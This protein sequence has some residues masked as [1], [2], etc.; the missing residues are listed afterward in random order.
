MVTHP[1]LGVGAGMFHNAEELWTAPHNSF[2]Q[3][4]AELGLVG[5][6]IFGFLLYRGVKNC[7]T[8]I[9][10]AHNDPRRVPY[11]SLA[12][13]LEIALYGYVIAGFSLSHGY[14]Y[15]LYFLLGMSVA[16]RRLAE[17][18]AVDDALGTAGSLR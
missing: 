4:G 17:N 10:L 18:A 15:L 12:G 6:G 11:S 5:L 8:V 1:L 14:S 13:G 9:R 7:R 3:V 16:L 2:L